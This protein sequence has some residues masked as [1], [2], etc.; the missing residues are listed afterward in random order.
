VDR[1]VDKL[2][3]RGLAQVRYVGP[4]LKDLPK[5]CRGVGYSRDPWLRNRA[6][7][8]EIKLWLIAYT[9][10]KELR[11]RRRK[12]WERYIVIDFTKFFNEFE[13]LCGSEAISSC[14]CIT[15]A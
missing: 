7:S 1:L 2:V 10:N 4:A 14:R 8:G 3:R 15:C 11:G 6:R 12:C 9:G 5:E 13:R